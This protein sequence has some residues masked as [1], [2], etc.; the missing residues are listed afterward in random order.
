L[1]NQEFSDL[2]ETKQ[3]GELI[4]FGNYVWTKR[5]AII[6]RR[7]QEEQKA[8]EDRQKQQ[9]QGG[10]NQRRFTPQYDYYDINLLPIPA[11][12]TL[13]ESGS[14]FI[15]D[16]NA[17]PILHHIMSNGAMEARLLVGRRR[18]RNPFQ[19][20]QNQQSQSTNGQQNGAKQQ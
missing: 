9:A 10:Q 20:Q 6:F 18:L 8:Y 11:A 2:L 12:N 3:D 1:T 14:H 19:F 17:T 16:Q 13:L 4:N 5:D 15:V 7:T